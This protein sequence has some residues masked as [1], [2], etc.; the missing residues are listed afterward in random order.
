[1]SK[2]FYEKTKISIAIT[3]M[4]KHILSIHYQRQPRNC[5]DIAL[6][7]QV[8]QTHTINSLPTPVKKLLI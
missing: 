1:M 8:E 5:V 6:F 4:R 3:S 2:F 7:L